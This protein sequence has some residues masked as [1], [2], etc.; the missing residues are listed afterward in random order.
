MDGPTAIITGITG[1]DGSYLRDFLLRK[2]YQVHGFLRSHA[3]GD[4]HPRVD[5]LH[6]HLA[7][8]ADADSLMPLLASIRP[9][10]IYHLAAQSN[11]RAS[12]ETP[13]A[14]TDANALGTIRLLEA[15][16]HSQDALGQPIRFFHASSG[17]IFRPNPEGALCETS[18]IDPQSP[19]GISKACA[20]WS[21]RTYRETFGLH[22]SNGILF[23]HESPLRPETFVT[24]KITKAAARIAH[25]LE[26]YLTLGALDS[27]RDW[28]Y[29][30][31]YVQGMWLMLQQ[32]QPDDYLLAT[33]KAHS[34]ED[35][36]RA[37]FQHVGLDYKKHLRQDEKFLRPKDA[38]C[39]IGDPTKARAKLGWE[40]RVG[41]QELVQLMVEAD[42]DKVAR[43][44]RQ[45]SR[46]A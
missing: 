5:G 24:R 2:G 9:Q 16:R 38:S 42:L 39:R 20:H 18:P 37:A 34:V 27:Q 15:I 11:V 36:T 41:F 44:S 33:G 12:F 8:L 23:N 45:E 14:T 1:Q 3:A 40:P 32:D 30:G 46:A 19:Y 26:Q 22:A 29:A 4:S 13:L 43:E 31:D 10:E 28:G 6:L 21:V 35:F 17:E 7:D 25:G